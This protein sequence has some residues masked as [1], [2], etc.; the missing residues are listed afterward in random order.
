MFKDCLS[1]DKCRKL[2]RL[3][4]HN[5]KEDKLS[6]SNKW[7]RPTTEFE[8]MV[9]LLELGWPMRSEIVPCLVGPPGIGKT[10]AIELHA[11][12][13]G[14]KVVKIVASRCVPSET[15]GMTM[16]DNEH[17]SMDIYNS[18][19]LSSLEDG[20]I[21]FLDELLEADQF[22]LSTLLTVIESREMA[23]GTPLPDIQ[24]VAA[25]NDTIPAEQ[26]KGNIR[27]RFLF[28]RFKVDRD[29][30][31]RY[32][33]ERTGMGM[34]V[35]VL[36]ALTSGE[37]CKSYNFLTPR[38]LTKLCLWIDSVDERQMY[39]VAGM[40]DKMFGSQLG[41]YIMRARIDRDEREPTP[42]E[43]VRQTVKAMAKDVDM[44]FENCTFEEMIEALKSSPEWS[45]IELVLANTDIKESERKDDVD[46]MF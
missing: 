20:D 10:A 41:T 19:Q 9:Q 18:R 8:R 31:A 16:P 27:Q 29:Q 42:E 33:K 3:M 32:I 15:V 28:E 7:P 1:C 40:I 23:D 25:T 38:T 45:V 17:R 26:L 37:S 13:H 12:N 34:P 21:L 39:G 46:I 35:A 22:V 44:D 2:D 30:T 11:R 14:S 4:Y 6:E 5:S 24:I 36:D 43:Q